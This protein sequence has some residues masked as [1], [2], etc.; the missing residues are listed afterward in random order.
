M[1]P[2]R[3]EGPGGLE[4]GLAKRLA[5]TTRVEKSEDENYWSGGQVGGP[6]TNQ[7]PGGRSPITLKLRSRA[8]PALATVPSS[9]RRPIKVTP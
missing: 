1:S 4:R 3:L 6:G 5:V 7:N 8:R 9:N 2:G